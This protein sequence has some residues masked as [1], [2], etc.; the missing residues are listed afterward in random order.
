MKLLVSIAMAQKPEMQKQTSNEKNRFYADFRAHTR[1]FKTRSKTLS[2]HLKATPS[3]AQDVMNSRLSLLLSK[4]AGMDIELPAEGSIEA[5]GA[6][7]AG[8]SRAKVRELRT[9]RRR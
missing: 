1:E 7:D 9:Q 4:E 3:R 8:P 2:A 5:P 6:A